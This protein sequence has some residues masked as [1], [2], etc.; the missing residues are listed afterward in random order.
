M[1]I[2]AWIIL[3]LIAGFLAQALVGG[4]YGLLGTIVLGIIGAVVG[5]WLAAQLGVGTVDGIDVASIV[6]ATV[7]AIIVI[8]IARSIRGR[9]LA[10]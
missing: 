8:W 1:G 10:R 5:G 7:G 3:G 6:I 9:R 4:G 2:L